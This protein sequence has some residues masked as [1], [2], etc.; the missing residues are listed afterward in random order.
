MMPSDPT[1]SIDVGILLRPGAGYDASHHWRSDDGRWSA[2]IRFRTGGYSHVSVQGPAAA[3][4]ELAAALVDAAAQ[5]DQA[6]E[7]EEAEQSEPVVGVR[8]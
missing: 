8:S 5:A 3:L 2:S 7:A 4:R 6:E 1:P